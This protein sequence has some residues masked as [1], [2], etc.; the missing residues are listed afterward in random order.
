MIPWFAGRTQLRFWFFACKSPFFEGDARL[1]DQESHPTS[2]MSADSSTTLLELAGLGSAAFWSFAYILMIRRGFKD[3][4]FAEPVTVCCVNFAWEFLFGFHY[5]VPDLVRH[6]NQIWMILT[7]IILWTCW[8]HGPDDFANPFIRKWLRPSLLPII[9]LC[10][11]IEWGFV[12]AFQD[13]F[14][15]ALGCVTGVINAVVF[16]AMLLRRQSIK[17]QSC[18]IALGMFLGNACA[19]YMALEPFPVNSVPPPP[20]DTPEILVK[21]LFA[22]ML[23]L[24]FLYLLLTVRQCRQE[25]INPWRRF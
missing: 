1:S 18:Y 4:T 2:P 19:L 23:P 7:G 16:L 17:G 3:R 5:A 6:G 21:T 25:G 12:E 13:Y 8:K 9:G 24:N 15:K 20:P 14:G 22:G 11:L 10:L